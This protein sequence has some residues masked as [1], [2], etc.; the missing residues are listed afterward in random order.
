MDEDQPPNLS[1][2]GRSADRSSPFMPWYFNIGEQPKGY[3]DGT[4][5]NWEDNRE[6]GFVSAG[7]L[8]KSVREIQHLSSGDFIY[9]Y[10]KGYGYVGLG[11]VTSDPVPARDLRLPNGT[12]LY[13]AKLRENCVI[14]YHG[15]SD[16]STE[17]AVSIEWLKTFS[18]NEAKTYPRIFAFP[19]AV[20]K[21]R[22]TDTLRFLDREFGSPGQV[23]VSREP[24]VWIEK[25]N[26]ANRA[27]RPSGDAAIGQMLWSPQ[28]SKTGA[29]IYRFMRDVVAG[30]IVL[31]LTDNE[32]FSGISEAAGR[33]QDF[34]GEDGSVWGAEPSQRV[35]LTG[36]SELEPS[37]HRDVFFSSPFRE[38]LVSLIASGQKNLFYNSAG[39][40][41][42]G[43]YLTPAPPALIR[44]LND[45][46]VS[47]AGK[48]LI[49]GFGDQGEDS[50]SSLAEDTFAFDSLVKSTY[51]TETALSS[52]IESIRHPVRPS[53][54]IILAG[55]PGTSKTFVAQEL[56]HY[57][58]KGDT[59]RGRVV[60]F[61]PSY[62][63]EQ[64]I[65]G[66]RPT[67]VDGAVQFQNVNGIVLDLAEKCRDSGEDHYLIIDELNRANLPRVLGELMYL[68]EYRDRKID[69][70]YTREF[71]L[72]PNLFFIATMNTADRNIRSIDIALRRR[73]DVFEC[74]PDAGVL[75]RFYGDDANRCD[76]PDLIT[77]FER[78]NRDLAVHLDEHHTIG[79]AFFMASHFTSDDL[80]AVW[81]RKIQP[82][83]SEY[84]FASP[85][86]ARTFSMTELWPSLA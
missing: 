35:P 68:F 58:T 67:I 60:Q 78:L 44:I 18:R 51:W 5:R 2:A 65:E 38:R 26:F 30:D 29:D 15:D 40:F 7:R 37:L 69:L 59:R 22:D 24:R 57:L 62:S 47:V 54:Q 3:P 83:L 14:E 13:D 11:R 6:L 49:Q 55:P 21:L 64:F 66:L 23:S 74:P 53:R 41:N 45:A 84:F 10:L 17:Y 8:A 36:F 43:A 19:G 76:V 56:V 82:L 73:F 28:K 81:T 86:I 50:I 31:H 16:E 80:E 9:A 52:I 34:P 61:H 63:Y 20:C 39:G 33:A 27:D 77:G 46:Y 4:N 1:L 72:P 70:P 12:Q 85:D 79:H 42:Q 48:P 71:S 25:T 32:A 75:Q